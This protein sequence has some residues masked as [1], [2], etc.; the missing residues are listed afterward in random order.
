MAASV[1]ATSALDAGGCAEHVLDDSGD[2]SVYDRGGI[3]SAFSRRVM[4]GLQAPVERL[5]D[6]GSRP[7]QSEFGS[8][9]CREPGA[10][11]SSRLIPVLGL[12]RR[13]TFLRNHRLPSGLESCSRR[14]N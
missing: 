9:P 3:L 7:V 10:N 1:Q 2:R 13:R 8:N 14:Q 12:P 11:D 6:A 4:Q 5:L